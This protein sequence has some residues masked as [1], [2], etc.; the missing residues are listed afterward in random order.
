MQ[1]ATF[2]A[3]YYAKNMK[4]NYLLFSKKIFLWPEQYFLMWDWQSEGDSHRARQLEFP[5]VPTLHWGFGQLQL[6]EVYWN[7]R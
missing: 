1:Q 7:G 5:G 3:V 2:K 6:D 4:D